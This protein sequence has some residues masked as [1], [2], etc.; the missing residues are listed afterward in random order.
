M[1]DG[2]SRTKFEAWAEEDLKLF[3]HTVRCGTINRATVGGTG[4]SIP[5]PPSGKAWELD[6][7]RDGQSIAYHRVSQ[8]I[9]ELVSKHKHAN[10]ITQL[11]CWV[12]YDQ[13]PIREFLV[14]LPFSSRRKTLGELGH[15]FEAAGLITDLRDIVARLIQ[16]EQGDVAV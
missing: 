16:V 8:A 13:R 11:V 12:Y 9:S 10:G 5:T 4:C 3:A 2:M 7:R 6:T 14:C 1:G 15:H